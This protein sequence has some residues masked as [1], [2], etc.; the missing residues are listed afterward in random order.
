MGRPGKVIIKTIA[1][2]LILALQFQ[3]IVSRAGTKPLSLNQL[4]IQLADVDKLEPAKHVGL[5]HEQLRLCIITW[6]ASQ[7]ETTACRIDLGEAQLAEM[8]FADAETTLREALTALDQTVGGREKSNLLARGQSLLG[9]V[10]VQQG[11]YDE[12]RTLLERAL[13]QQP[14]KSV[15]RFRTLARLSQLHEAKQLKNELTKTA[16]ETA[17]A[18]LPNMSVTDQA[19]LAA[20][21]A[22]LACVMQS[23]AMCADKWEKVLALMETAYAKN[24]SRLTLAL[25][26]LAEA[27]NMLRDPQRAEAIGDRILQIERSRLRPNSRRLGSALND[28]GGL[29]GYTNRLDLAEQVQKEAV[30]LAENDPTAKQP[31]AMRLANLGDTLLGQRKYQEA[32]P[33]LRRAVELTISIFGTDNP[34]STYPRQ[35]LAELLG[36]TGR[37]PEA[38]ALNSENVRILTSALGRDHRYTLYAM[39][40]QGSYLLR[41]KQLTEAKKVLETALTSAR[42]TFGPTAQDTLGIQTTYFQALLDSGDTTEAIREARAVLLEIRAAALDGATR[43]QTKAGAAD[44]F[45]ITINSAVRLRNVLLKIAAK[46]SNAV[47]D[48]LLAQQFVERYLDGSA[49]WQTGARLAAEDPALR[50]LADEQQVA[51]AS[52][53][54][55]RTQL[56]TAY[57]ERNN[58][59]ITRLSADLD[60]DREAASKITATIDARYPAFANLAG[61]RDISLNELT[62]P[63]SRLLQPDE[64]ALFLIQEPKGHYA[65]LV[66]RGYSKLVAAPIDARKMSAL[67]A[68]LRAGI[69]IAGSVTK[70][71]L[72]IFDLKA[73]AALYQSIIAPFEVELRGVQ[74]LYTS[75]DGPLASLPLSV[76]VTKMPTRT[77]NIFA[78]YRQARW[79][80][81]KYNIVTL[82]AINALQALKLV[83]PPS[84]ADRPLLAIADPALAGNKLSTATNSFASLRSAQT[85][86]NSPMRTAAAVCALRSLPDT[87]REAEAMA[88]AM[89]A[90]AGSMLFGNVASEATLTSLSQSGELRRYRALLF[91][92]HGLAAGSTPGEEPAIIL[93]PNGGC[94]E[95]VAATTKEPDDGLLTSSEITM[96]SLDAD[97]VVLSGCNT[98]SGDANGASRPLSGLAR[99]FLYAGARQIIVSHWSVDSAATADLMTFMARKHA[100]GLSYSAA[101][102]S[103]MRSLRND[104]NGPTYQ[105]HP[106]FWAA[107]ST[108]GES[109]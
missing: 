71:D 73:S 103:A 1:V 11:Q 90:S 85:A 78:A 44:R 25:G 53:G 62:S 8:F 51:I 105:S 67:V 3:I 91:A 55:L 99:A 26:P 18:Q 50:Q 7:L 45:A 66:K 101:L 17:A 97:V 22:R 89:G 83:A 77:A 46:N 42:I 23:G 40:Y 88:K 86:G 79:F 74:T 93:T 65:L 69:A 80:S 54:K 38:I 107:F 81:D 98:A 68:G 30:A 12:A 84:K 10:L 92:T 14:M 100:D 49:A 59:E 15:E 58:G 13:A 16:A 95:H 47:Q 35:G 33:V 75:V 28:L 24:D 60:R 37:V 106:A 48:A 5:A 96:L 56:A 32:E 21:D 20:T 52:V 61:G 70:S 72:P 109:R 29:Y 39:H 41:D 43:I 102:R 19:L 108:V 34:N 76:L 6:G 94:R 2:I 104:R 27:Y 64:A 4:R 31:L 63:N 9:A 82:P 57:R 36:S 87:R